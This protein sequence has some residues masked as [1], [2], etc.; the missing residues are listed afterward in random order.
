MN[1]ADKLIKLRK[2]NGL[3][4]EEL[5]DKLDVTRQAI[6][7]WESGQSLPD[8]QNVLSLS[9]LFTV[10]TDYLLKDDIQDIQYNISDCS[11]VQN[12]QNKAMQKGDCN[13][14]SLPYAYNYLKHTNT[15]SAR[16]SVAFIMCLMTFFT[17]TILIFQHFFFYTK[18]SWVV[19]LVIGIICAVI[20]FFS[21]NIV[22]YNTFVQK[23]YRRLSKPFII[24]DCDIDNLKTT[25]AK[26][27]KNVH[28]ICFCALTVLFFAIITAT[29]G[30]FT[31][32]NIIVLYVVVFALVAFASWV[33]I[34]SNAKYYALQK[35]IT[36]DYTNSALKSKAKK[37]GIFS[38]VY[39]AVV[40]IALLICLFVGT[41]AELCYAVFALAVA[42]YLLV[43]A[44][45][46]SLL[47][48]T[49][50]IAQ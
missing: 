44:T 21:I 38:A 39:W 7:K 17:S 43:V 1:F 34:F 22:I 29:A 5:A 31:L 45:V 27:F 19:A 49:Y 46:F 40:L 33:I 18:I 41:K 37:T 9:K 47:N 48:K 36:Q 30:F 8:L 4:Q 23:K 12:M 16:L 13:N 26:F 28:R 32:K 3:S 10:S 14:V 35:L 24:N 2:T 6:S 42:F 20:L 11:E 50:G 15:C 25:Y